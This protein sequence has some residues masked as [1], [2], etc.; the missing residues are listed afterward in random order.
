[1]RCAVTAADSAGTTTAE[2]AVY[3]VR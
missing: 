2:S 1:V 3:R